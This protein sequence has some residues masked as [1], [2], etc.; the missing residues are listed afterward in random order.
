MGF[1]SILTALQWLVSLP[2]KRIGSIADL[3]DAFNL[4]FTSNRHFEK[5]TSNLYK[6]V[7]KYM[8]PLREYLTRFN[9][10]NITIQNCDIPTTIEAF[11]SGLERDL[12]LFDELTKYPCKN[13]G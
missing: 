8:E 4:Q 6:I 3:V 13:N 7:H 5:I 10:E 11:R 12:P 1:G 9:M 2:N